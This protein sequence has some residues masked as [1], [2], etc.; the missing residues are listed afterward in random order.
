M[1]RDVDRRH[2]AAD[3]YDPAADGELGQILGLPKFGDEG[4]GVDDV[5]EHRLARQPELI[6]ARQPDP[7]EHGVVVS[8]KFT[9]RDVASQGDARFHLDP[10]DAEDEI[11]LAGGEIVWGLIR[12]DPV[13]VEPGR[14]FH[15]DSDRFMLLY[16]ML[17]LLRRVCASETHAAKASWPRSSVG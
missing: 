15:L 4:D 3:H 5:G 2:A 7:N 6:D 1:D 12:R 11:R 8:R 17:R 14:L 13:F 9:E 16:R 10:A